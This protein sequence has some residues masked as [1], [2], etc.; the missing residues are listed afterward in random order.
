MAGPT[1]FFA[2]NLAALATNGN[3]HGN[4]HDRHVGWN[5]TT[6]VGVGAVDRV[7]RGGLLDHGDVRQ[8]VFGRK[9]NFWI[10]LWVDYLVAFV[11]AEWS[12]IL[13][14]MA[15][16]R[17]EATM[18]VTLPGIGCVFGRGRWGA[19]IGEQAH[20]VLL[21][22][23]A[24]FGVL[25]LLGSLIVV[26]CR[27]SGRDLRTLGIFIVVDSRHCGRA[28]RSQ[29]S[30]VVAVLW[31]FGNKIKAGS[32]MWDVHD[33]LGV[34]GCGGSLDRRVSLQWERY[35]FDVTLAA[36]TYLCL[37]YGEGIG[38]KHNWIRLRGDLV[39]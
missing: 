6:A 18:A 14:R 9:G 13:R 5:K 24:T 20:G 27:G 34:E 36:P 29:G 38:A 31:T 11:A 3:T 28:A 35:S 19:K 16:G 39:C 17:D 22:A 37:K 4:T 15:D 30:L 21:P 32:W 12:S 26:D 8:N 33:V 7:W 2:G 23:H 1:A 10:V 25:G